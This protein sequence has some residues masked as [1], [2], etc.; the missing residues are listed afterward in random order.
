MKTASRRGFL[1]S[2][3]ALA[4]ASLVPSVVE[5]AVPAQGGWDLSFLDRLNGR[6]KQV[7][8]LM[9]MEIGLVVV[10]NW[11][12]A[13]ESVFALRSPEVSAAVGVAGKGFPVAV[14]D[15]VYAK[16]PIGEL[17]KVNDP[18]TG[19]AATRNP[20]AAGDGRGM[21]AGAG[22]RPLQARGATFWMC[23]NAL[24]AVSGRIATAVQKPQPDVYQDLRSGLL[25]GVILVP[26]HTL[27]IG[28]AQEKGF[29]YEVA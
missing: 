26:A 1:T 28:L 18:A 23:N 21:F 25:P 10:K 3:S 14:G 11:L 19:K 2:V 16:Y 5:A 17:W 15:D 29:S 22:V 9:D 7:F 4:G 20:F 24:N 12:D 27:L 6:H 13:W 8:D